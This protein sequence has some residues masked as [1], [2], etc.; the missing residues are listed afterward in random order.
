MIVVPFFFASHQATEKPTTG[1]YPNRRQ[2]T[3]LKVGNYGSC[4]SSHSSSVFIEF[5]APV[6]WKSW[7]DSLEASFACISVE[8]KLVVALDHLPTCYEN[9]FDFHTIWLNCFFNSPPKVI[10]LFCGNRL[11]IPQEFLREA[12]IME[13]HSS[14]LAA[15]LG[16]EKTYDSQVDRS[17]WPQLRKDVNNLVK[18]CF[19]CR[20]SKGHLYTPLPIPTNIW[21]DLSMIF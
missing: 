8:Q 7:C 9:D 4:R 13:A 10:F 11:C 5:S 2:G 20:T 6:H 3:N 21:E 17:F 14:G 15:Q 1:C 18:R 16:R 12:I 19:I